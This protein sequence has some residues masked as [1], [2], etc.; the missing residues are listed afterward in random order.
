V[1]TKLLDPCLGSQLLKKMV[2]NDRGW[3][4]TGGELT[5]LLMDENAMG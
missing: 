1:G 5:N 4:S 2:V 3:F